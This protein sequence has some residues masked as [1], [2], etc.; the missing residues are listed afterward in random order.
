MEF[1]SKGT[2]HRK[3]QKPTAETTN[4]RLEGENILKL[5]PKYKAVKHIQKTARTQL[6]KEISV[7]HSRTILK[8]S[9]S[10]SIQGVFSRNTAQFFRSQST[11]GNDRNPAA[12]STLAP[13]IM[14]VKNRSL[15]QVIT[16]FSTSI[17]TGGRVNGLIWM[18]TL[19]CFR[20]IVSQLNVFLSHWRLISFDTSCYTCCV[21]NTSSV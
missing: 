10:Y 9:D 12:N 4:N 21:K 19:G 3:S 17:I 20:F 11:Q 14:E 7:E 6:A 5:R 8:P 2:N 13:V 18:A 16:T 15:H 1:G